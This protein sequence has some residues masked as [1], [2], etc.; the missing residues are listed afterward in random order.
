M[1]QK[2]SVCLVDDTSSV[3]SNYSYG[4]VAG[5]YSDTDS[6][7]TYQA[8]SG[9]HRPT[10][11][12]N[13]MK[14]SQNSRTPLLN[15]ND[16][17]NGYESIPSR[18]Y[19]NMRS[20]DDCDD[21]L[22]STAE[23]KEVLKCNKNDK[24]QSS[25][26]T[27]FAVWNTVM[28]SSLLTMAWGIDQAGLLVGLLLTI[29]MG[30]LCLFTAYVL[31]N[32]CQNH[33]QNPSFEV[34]D[35][36]RFLL[37]RWAEVIARIFS[38]IVMLGANIVYWI[39]M[40][41][42]LF[43]TV[44]YFTDSPSPNSTI[45]KVNDSTLC[46]KESLLFGTNN[47]ALLPDPGAIPYESPYWGLRTTVPIYVA[48][49]VFPIL[50]FKNATF[51][52]KFNTLGTL[53][54]LYLLIFVVVKGI[55]WGIH[56]TNWISEFELKPNA[57]VLSGM[58]ALSFYIHNIIITIMRSNRQQDKNGRDLSIAFI[59]VMV[60]YVLVG[61]IFYICFPLDK[62]CIED[63]LLN[64]FDKHDVMTA[65]ARILL[66]FQVITVYPLIAYM[67][68]IQILSL[69]PCKLQTS[70]YSVI[71]LNGFFV[72]VCILFACFCPKI[73]TIIR[74]TG[75]VSGLIHIFTLPSLLQ[76]RSLY[77]R[78]KLTVPK[79]IFYFVIFFI[80]AA[81]LLAQFFIAE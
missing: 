63:N 58:L 64:N 21:D 52:T 37:G 22:L 38:L 55:G 65:V 29:L 24:M 15:R 10:N 18:N 30:A 71:A 75:A 44:N 47:S 49:I 60:T 6:E 81:N 43:F 5:Q 4:L 3:E 1:K 9:S 77:L 33:S 70:I 34:P 32:V 76:V 73:G 19:N 14:E 50:N 80:G 28:G 25:L 51:F 61:A 7:Y 78:R 48:I 39:L 53:S 54:V 69:L 36:C 72:V 68:R 66:L 11:T 12:T 26:V 74:Y 59:L 62:H 35:L 31:L 42:F 46:P 13:K 17:R 20:I 67:L 23:V 16:T 8:K 79:A 40:S 27:I 56:M 45:V 41:N 57:G 2:R